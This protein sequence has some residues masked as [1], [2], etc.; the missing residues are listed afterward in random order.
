MD[1]EPDRELEV[2][3]HQ[4]DATKS[5]LAEKI[6]ALESQVTETVAG[7]TG[8]VS[9]VTETVSNVTEKVTGT[10]QSLSET[11]TGTVQNLT[12]TVGGTV[13]SLTE[14]VSGT[15][16]TVRDT[17]DITP[18]IRAHPW[19]SVGCAVAVGMVGGFLL[20]S[21][22]PGRSS[23]V[24]SLL[25]LGRAEGAPP[26]AEPRSYYAPAPT[27]APAPTSNGHHAEPT[28]LSA[29]GETFGDLAGTL[30]SYGISALM[31]VVSHL[32][33]DAVPEAI[34]GDVTGALDSLKT[35]LGGRH[36]VSPESFLSH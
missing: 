22:R 17:L 19:S 3:K 29:V 36:S 14:T 15:V 32:V 11:V 21:P 30:R 18:T 25:G 4:M 7:V 24:S 16:Q 9:A 8:A 35:K 5:S 33:K 27:P 13:N 23:R 2:I 28:A 26:P 6:G 10:V 31:G 34:R 12:S 1:S 20:S